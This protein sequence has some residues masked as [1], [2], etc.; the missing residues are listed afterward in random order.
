MTREAPPSK[1]IPSSYAHDFLDKSTLLYISD[2]VD[3]P[4]ISVVQFNVIAHLHDLSVTLADNNSKIAEMHIRGR[5]GHYF[6]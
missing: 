4:P 6:Q 1:F 3:E 2:E 5:S